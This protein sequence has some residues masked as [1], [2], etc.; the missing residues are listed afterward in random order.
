MVLKSFLCL[1][2]QRGTAVQGQ[3]KA[4]SGPKNLLEGIFAKAT[5][6]QASGQSGI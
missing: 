3:P 6:Q 1:S 5:A 4:K 2:F